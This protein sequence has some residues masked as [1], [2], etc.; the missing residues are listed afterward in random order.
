MKPVG[1]YPTHGPARDIPGIPASCRDQAW[2]RSRFEWRVG[3]PGDPAALV[4]AFLSRHNLIVNDLSGRCSSEVPDPEHDICGA[5]LFVSAA[6]GAV[7]AGGALGAPSP[8]PAVPD[9]VAVV[10]EHSAT[11]RPQSEPDAP[12]GQTDGDWRLGPWRPSW[13]P[14]AHAAAV[15]QVRASIARGDVYQ[16]NVVGHASAPYAGDPL[17]ALRRL[18]RLAGARYAGIL[19]GDGWAIGCGS[20]ETLLRVRDGEALTRPIKGTAPATEAGRAELLAS[21]KERAEHVMIVDLMRNDLS[22]VAVTGSVR[23]PRLFALRPWC[24]LWQAESDVTARIR[25]GTGLADLLR[26]VCPGGSVTG[27]P[28]LAAL[29]EIAR[30]EPVGRGVSMGAL[31][32]IG[33]DGIDLGLTIRTAAVD[34]GLVHVWAGG[35]ITIDSDPAAEVAEA[36]AKAAPVRAALRG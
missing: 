27:A 13:T 21:P 34:E 23:V 9:V 31:G 1:L 28:K 6:G 7:L 11:V 32:W 29:A 33:R 5:A 22:H 36:A 4:E 3:D 15:E 17:P 16:V 24:D 2:E 26:A 35:G 12:S 30:L 14:A 20:P 25:P 18:T 8:V 19:R 10:Y